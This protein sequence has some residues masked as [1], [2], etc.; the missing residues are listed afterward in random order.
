MVG[1]LE[2]LK[3]S[4]YTV[5][6]LRPSEEGGR[7]MHAGF[8]KVANRCTD[9]LLK[10]A[11]FLET[12]EKEIHVNERHSVL[13]A[14]IQEV[15]SV[16]LHGV[17]PDS[18]EGQRVKAATRPILEAFLPEPLIR[19]LHHNSYLNILYTSIL[20]ARDPSLF[21][22]LT[23]STG[24]GGSND[25]DTN[26]RVPAYIIPGLKILESLRGLQQRRIIDFR[27]PRFRVFFA[28]HTATVINAAVMNSDD[29]LQNM[30]RTCKYLSQYVAHFHRDIASYVQF[31]VE[32]P[33]T[34]HD[35][36][37]Q[38]L[39]NHYSQLLIESQEESIIR[40][41]AILRER[42]V[43]HGNEE[44]ARR[45][46][47]YAAMHPFLFKDSLNHLPIN[48]FAQKDKSIFALSLGGRPE[49]LFNT[50]RDFIRHVTQRNPLPEEALLDS[51]QRGSDQDTPTFPQRGTIFTR[52]P[53]HAS[54]PV[55][56]MMAI[57]SVGRTPV[58]Y[59]TAYDMGI[60]GY[61]NSPIAYLTHMQEVVKSKLS[62]R[63]L[64][65]E[66]NRLR[67]IEHDIKVLIEDAGSE[68]TLMGFLDGLD[69]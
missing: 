4:H 31:E 32:N 21:Q 1:Q 57:T 15:F 62:G 45:A 11:V 13:K 67:E 63:E 59:R 12:G 56:N 51:S 33:W 9:F 55:V 19:S 16:A 43:K 27:L 39:L 48:V 35:T 20:L 7:M 64:A 65:L 46:Y 60:G 10:R 52:R 18:D 40:S 58:Y 17:N 22:E 36:V 24:Y 49:R 23:I 38:S 14:E 2:H 54:S 34:E 37:T 25:D 29:V 42:G 8:Q 41:L 26:V 44:G 68:E 66:L 28:P 6:I 3:G 53:T 61:D 69:N 47:V 30:E 5:N 50:L